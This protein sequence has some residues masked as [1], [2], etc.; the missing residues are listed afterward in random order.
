[1]IPKPFFLQ[2]YPSF[3]A[4]SIVLAYL[5]LTLYGTLVAL[6]LGWLIWG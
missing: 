2:K 5:K 3:H 6:G 1:M 4:T